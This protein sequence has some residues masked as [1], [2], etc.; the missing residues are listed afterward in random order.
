[1][2]RMAVPPRQVGAAGFEPATSPTRT[3][4]AAGLRHAPTIYA[5]IA[6]PFA[7]DKVEI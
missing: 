3:V 4:R 5:S 2:R 1:M 6:K 7:D